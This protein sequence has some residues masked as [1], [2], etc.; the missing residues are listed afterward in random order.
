MSGER[1]R[2]S[3]P[4]K[5]SQVGKVVAGVAPEI[6]SLN[7]TADQWQKF[8]I[9]LQGLS[10][11]RKAEIS[12]VMSNLRL[13]PDDPSAI[14]LAVSGRVEALAEGIQ[15][16]F[17]EMLDEACRTLKERINQDF[18]SVEDNIAIRIAEMENSAMAVTEAAVADATRAAADVSSKEFS[19]KAAAQIKDMSEKIDAKLD[20]VKATVKSH[21]DRAINQRV[22][23]ESKKAADAARGEVVAVKSFA[24]GLL[25]GAGLAALLFVIALAQRAHGIPG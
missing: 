18:Q 4:A 7:A 2:S 3:G 11:E 25:V 21:I 13:R 22:K 6:V 8:D 1:D 20:H 10:D 12:R 14:L 16:D 23:E 5:A 9:A 19:E 15:G 17:D 24:A